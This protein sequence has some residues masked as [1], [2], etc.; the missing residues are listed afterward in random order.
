MVFGAILAGGL[1]S[2][3][4]V[5][6]VPKQFKL[7]G[8]K[9][10]IIH[11]IEKFL[12]CDKIKY[13]YVGVH[14]DWAQYMQDLMKKYFENIDNIKISIGGNDRNSTIMNIIEDI[15]SEFG[16]S[17]ENVI[18]THDSVRPFVTLRIINDNIDCALKKGACNTVV[19]ANDTIL[20]ANDSLVTE[21]PNR[22]YIYQG[23]T[24]QSFKITTLKD[25]Y[26]DLTSNE[27]DI[28]TDACKVLVLRNIPVHLV[29][30][31]DFNIKI[32]TPTD[33]KI[34]QAILKEEL[35]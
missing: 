31:E 24:P 23:Q 4:G 5:T 2:R 12:M 32:T 25:I 29:K 1:G 28:L 26:N 18:I 9:P 19:P 34:A 17:E 35:F 33:Y 7:L 8:D 13:I 14:K 11:T 16:I 10:I 3:M 20:V 21:I 15:E 22:N 27:R 30:G 6:N